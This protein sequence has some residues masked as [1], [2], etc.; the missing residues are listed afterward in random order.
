M[1]KFL[2]NLLVQISKPLVYSKIKFYS[3]KNFSRHFRRIRP[4]GPVSFFSFQP[5]DFPSPPPLGLD[6]LAGPARQHGPTSHLLLPPAPEPS[7]PG[8]VG[9]PRAAPWVD[10]DTS[11]GGKENS[12]INPFIPPLID[13]VSPSSITGNRRLQRRPLKLLQHRPLKTLGLASAL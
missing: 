7:V 11:T 3:E 12:R 2:L 8:A 6:L 1:L 10:P 5:A 4:F 9:R 13:T